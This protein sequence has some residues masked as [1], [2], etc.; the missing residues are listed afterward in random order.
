MLS[1]N[2]EN[3]EYFEEKQNAN[4]LQNNQN[5]FELKQNESTFINLYYKII[6][7][8]IFYCLLFRV[9]ENYTII[10]FKT[11]EVKI[12]I[13]FVVKMSKPRSMVTAN[14]LYD[15]NVLIIGS[16]PDSIDTDDIYNPKNTKNYKNYAIR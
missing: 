2:S 3:N 16:Y 7:T 15:G 1:T 11:I 14:T 6:L 4:S 12:R 8:I 5:N 9:N 10:P 13:G